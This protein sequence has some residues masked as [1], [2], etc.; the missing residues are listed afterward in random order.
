MDK[1]YMSI[2]L[3]YAKI[4]FENDEVPVGCIIVKDDIVI[5]TGYNQKESNQNPLDHAEIIAIKEASK[6]LNTWRLE[7]CTLYVT[8]EPCSM[9][10]GAII[11][12]RIKKVVFGTM[13]PKGGSF[14]SVINLTEI[15]GFNHY[16]EIVSGILM[17]ESKQLLKD[18]FKSKRLN[19]SY[20]TD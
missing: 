12:S 8:L 2:A 5:A 20:E 17:N 13:D 6:K 11:Q 18:F 7:D 16:P 1:H 14:G 4:A 10:A 3:D 19:R 9:C 15:K